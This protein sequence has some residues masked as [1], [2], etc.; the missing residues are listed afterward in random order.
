MSTL[1]FDIETVGEDW[2]A[3]DA[4]SQHMLTRWI[5]RAYPEG[6]DREAKLRDLA[7][8]LGFSPLTGSIVAIGV[9]SA[10]KDEGAVYF[11]CGRE[12]S[13]SDFE[14]ARIKYKCMTEKEMIEQFWI[15]AKH[16]EQ[17][18]TFNG[19]V[20]DVPFII[21]RSMVY[22]I[23]P[24]KDLMSNRY[25]SSQKFG[26]KHIDLRDQLSFYGASNFKGQ[27]LHMWCRA[28]GIESP[29]AHGI[30]GDDV[31]ELFK[32]GKYETIARYN[33]GDLRATRTLYLRWRDSL[34]SM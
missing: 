3:L 33:A 30:D 7:E 17:F 31:S 12:G 23:A 18:V 2:D 27:S 4:T 14:E 15:V 20:F 26:A 19:R 22:G 28:L 32:A 13:Q 5:E 6:A 9:L 34:S 21:A 24:T 10:E 11:S 8:E 25:L 16:S 1:I 29:K